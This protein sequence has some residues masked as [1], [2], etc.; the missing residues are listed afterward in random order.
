MMRQAEKTKSAASPVPAITSAGGSSL[1]QSG[2]STTIGGKP[3][4]TSA[5]RNQPWRRMI[6]S[7]ESWLQSSEQPREALHEAGPGRHAEQHS[8]VHLFARRELGEPLGDGVLGHHHPD[9]GISRSLVFVWHARGM[10]EDG[11]S[12]VS[13]AGDRRGPQRVM[14][15][16]PPD[17]IR[18]PR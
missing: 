12:T 10:P 17:G 7:A 6:I 5:P 4:V 1:N 8:A 16:T 18:V 3:S 13:G 15:W 2:K 14:G 11:F 9:L